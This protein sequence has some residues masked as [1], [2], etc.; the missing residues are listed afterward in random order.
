MP[1]HSR[2]RNQAIWATHGVLRDDVVR[3]IAA[4]LQDGQTTSQIAAQ[5]NM[6]YEAA[7]THCRR[8]RSAL[9]LPSPAERV[10]NN[11][12]LIC[13]L[14]R[15]GLTDDEIASRIGYT[16]RTVGQ[17]RVELGYGVRRKLALSEAEWQE[18]DRR[19]T[20]GEKP[21]DVARAIGIAKSTLQKRVV[22]VRDK[23][24]DLPPCGCG[25]PANHSGGCSAPPEVIAHVR[26]RLTN[27][28][29]L[30]H[31]AAEVGY[32]GGGLRTATR[33]LLAELRAAGVKCACGKPVTHGG[34]CTGVGNPTL[35]AKHADLIDRLQP[36]LKQGMSRRAIAI[37][38]GVNTGTIYQLAGPI[39]KEWAASGMKCDCGQPFDHKGVC[40][41]RYCPDRRTGGRRAARTKY[42][43]TSQKLTSAQRLNIRG[44]AE[45]GRTNE[46]IAAHLQISEH[47][48]RSVILDL[49]AAGV[50]F[51]NCRC[52][53]PR[54]HGGKCLPKQRQHRPTAMRANAQEVILD[55]VMWRRVYDAYKIGTPAS[56]IAQHTGLSV[57]V[58]R[59]YINRWLAKRKKPLPPCSCGRAAHHA[60]FCSRR[61]PLALNKRWARRIEEMVMAGRS[62]ATIAD[63]LRLTFQT[64]AK[65]AL[66]A[67]QKLLAMGVNCGCGRPLWH[68]GACSA[69]WA[70]SGR[71]TGARPIDPATERRITR[72][73][74]SGAD[75]RE[76]AGVAQASY[77]QVVRVRLAMSSEDRA[78]RSVAIR[79]RSALLKNEHNALD[80]LTA[81]RAAVPRW[82]DAN[83]RDEI[84][85]EVFVAVA[86][87]RIDTDEIK[88]AV[89]TIARKGLAAWLPA[90][91]DAA[92]GETGDRSLHDLVGDDTANNQIEELS[93]GGNEE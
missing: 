2:A 51:G 4:R 90:S 87:G 82:V 88:A 13:T 74:L 29:K 66:P 75:A 1:A 67:R 63:D 16:T 60:G 85:N 61:V 45:R 59:K 18:I 19:L 84:V 23:I 79:R 5:L 20:A 43:S 22:A 52:G 49:A 25:R 26:K 11:Y 15:E 69:T 14:A 3:D 91:M 86:E 62:V 64:V 38:L 65:Y 31:I 92:L 9:D 81:L 8:I 80:L 40:A 50:A 68:S 46:H 76:V 89:R 28:A 33:A 48:V 24:A 78:A 39:I 10:Q 54:S 17:L 70:A 83:Q 6:C 77:R 71:A 12:D 41:A 55:K 44:M 53:K 58:V 93:I 32:S 7:S 42:S 34:N 27:G 47:Y 72:A 37:K 35:A 56:T 57:D 21:G 36:M 30:E 73:L